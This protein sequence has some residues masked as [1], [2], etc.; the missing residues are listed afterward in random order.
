MAY[1]FID[2]ITIADN[3]TTEIQFSGLD[4]YTDAEVL[5]L[6]FN[7]KVDSNHTYGWFTGTLND[8]NHYAYSNGVYHLTNAQNPNNS[9]TNTGYGINGGYM[10]AYSSSYYRGIAG[11]GDTS[12]DL[13][14]YNW[15][16]GYIRFYNWS[17]TTETKSWVKFSAN[18]NSSKGSNYWQWDNGW[19]WDYGCQTDMYGSFDYEYAYIPVDSF[20]L[21][22]YNFSGGTT[23]NSGSNFQLYGWTRE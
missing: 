6:R 3:T 9:V 19:G 17:S 2:E 8:V 15:S 16:P 12:N 11:D 13:S 20:E 14:T 7:V 5:E 22:V 1:Q 21:Q 23:W 10:Y 18:I 4:A